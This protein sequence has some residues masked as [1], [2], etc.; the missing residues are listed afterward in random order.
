MT[1]MREIV[2][3]QGDAQAPARSGAMPDTDGA[4]FYLADHNL[5][6]A[7]RRCLAPGELAHAERILSEAGAVA[8]GE[9]NRLAALADKNPPQLVQ[10]DRRGER[11]DRVEHH[12]AYREMERIAFE[13]F[14]LSAVSHR[15]GALGW[16]GRMP[17][18]VKYAL[19]YVLIQAE[20][21]L[22]CPVNMTDSAAR[23]LALFGDERLKREFLPRLTATD[24]ESLAQGAQFLTEKQGG[25]DVG[26][27]STIARREHDG[28]RLYGDKWFC[29]NAGAELILTLARP[30][31]APEGTRGLALFLVPA[32]L[33]D[34]TRN[35]FTINRLKE[36]LG[37]RSM[38]SGEYTFAGALAN[39]VGPL[40]Q[41][42][43]QMMEMV[44]ASRLSN[45]MRAAA[46]MRRS[47]F[48]A[49]VHARGRM[50]FGKS[51][52]EL[53]LMREQLLELMLDVEAAVAVVLQ[54]G[55]ALGRA[56]AGSAEDRSLI[57]ILTPL[58]KW[59]LCKRVRWVTGEGM[60]VRGGNGYVEDWV[61]PRLVRDSHL[62]SIWE[63]ASTVILLDVARAM[64]KERSHEALIADMRRRLD[65]LRDPALADAAAVVRDSLARLER[66]FERLPSLEAGVHD[67]P[68]D[69]LV[70]R[71]YHLNV[72]TLLLDEADYQ[73]GTGRGYRKLLLA[74]RYLRAFVY[75][76]A[77]DALA[78]VDATAMDWFDALVEGG[79]VP[80]EASGGLIAALPR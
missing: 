64:A 80:A 20:F 53:P 62:G 25:S 67:L 23:V 30:E 69:R 57:R 1:A 54:A 42:F 14:Q 27:S 9:L 33:P 10:Y 66:Q 74:A 26:A 47:Y 61:N 21:G 32:H 24:L 56:D 55:V 2:P 73:A 70:R 76:P 29:S 48:E 3:D 41:G 63:G 16:P 72:A 17:A 49:L 52:A 8:G 39:P 65:A 12:P 4:N 77:D 19:S 11:V 46:L 75:P 45:A 15:D 78:E 34:G 60:E 44:S 37:S 50:A 6:L 58:A 5:A 59:Y 71:I 51:L 68:L 38:A 28:W 36:K 43:R 79:Y 18:V 13:R 35:R 7:L 31:G 22:F 40:E